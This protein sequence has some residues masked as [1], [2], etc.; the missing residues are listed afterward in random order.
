M[1]KESVR[2]RDCSLAHEQRPN[3]LQAQAMTQKSKHNAH[4]NAMQNKK[5]IMKKTNKKEWLIEWLRAKWE[6]DRRNGKKVKPCCGSDAFRWIYSMKSVKSIS[7]LT[8]FTNNVVD[9]S[10]S[11]SAVLFENGVIFNMV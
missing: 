8:G 10:V 2:A 11:D 3:K 6:W 4:K 1:F 9:G 7:S 5:N